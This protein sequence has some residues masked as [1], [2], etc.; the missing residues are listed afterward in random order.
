MLVNIFTEPVSAVV[1][2]MLVVVVP[3]VFTFFVPRIVFVAPVKEIFPVVLPML[4]ADVPILFTLVVPRIV[5]VVAFKAKVDVVSNVTAP[6]ALMSSAAQ[7]ISVSPP[8][9]SVVVVV[10]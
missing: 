1:F 10:D 5:F 4:V 2:P 7:L 9:V 8:L 3:A 6:V